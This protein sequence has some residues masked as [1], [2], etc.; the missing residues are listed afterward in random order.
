MKAKLS[1]YSFSLVFFGAF[2]ALSASMASASILVF[3]TRLALSD[4]TKA[5]YL[6]LRNTSNE[7]KTYRIA[8][9]YYKMGTDGSMSL[10]QEGADE[11]KDSA[12]GLLRFSPREVTIEPGA[13]QVVRVMFY[14]RRPIEDGEYRAHLRFEPVEAVE[15]A[16]ASAEAAD[17]AV[18]M[19][20][21]SKVSVSIPVVFS[22]GRIEKKVALVQPEII[23]FNEK[24]RGF[25]VKLKNEGNGFLYGNFRAEFFESSDAEKQ[26]PLLVGEVKGISSYI[27]ERLTRYP[28]YQFDDIKGKTGTLRLSFLE[29]EDD[30]GAVLSSIDIPRSPAS[31]EGAKQEN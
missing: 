5:G 26:K 11:L 6:S 25:Q 21:K 28:L 13:E 19:S 8:T 12:V 2:L 22:R 27:P 20:I 30:G 15:V 14:S 18:T 17:G 9:V 10:V 1:V 7:K 29:P 16:K 3:P 24:H 23:E 4:R 31:V